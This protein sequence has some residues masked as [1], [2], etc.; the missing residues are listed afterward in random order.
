MVLNGLWYVFQA[1]LV[2]GLAELAPD[3]RMERAVQLYHREGELFPAPLAIE[4]FPCL[5]LHTLR[6]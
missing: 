2:P 6:N 1:Q 3:L 4:L 5:F